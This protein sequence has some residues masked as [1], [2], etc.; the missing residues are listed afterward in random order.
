MSKW[1]FI[2][3]FKSDLIVYLTMV[4]NEGIKDVQ[5]YTFSAFLSEMSCFSKTAMLSFKF[6]TISA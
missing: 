4:L 3:F 5:M 1:E 6:F 2:V